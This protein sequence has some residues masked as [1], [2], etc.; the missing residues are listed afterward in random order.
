[1]ELISNDFKHNELMDKKF[2]YRADNKS[3][4][5]KWSDPP[6]S[7]KS[8]AISCN[9]PDAP[10]GDWIHW[11]VINIPRDVIEIPQGGPIPGK[12]LE[13]DYGQ[14]GY[15]GPAPPSGTHRYFFKVYALDIEKLEGVNKRNFKEK[16]KKYTLDSAEIIGLYK[17]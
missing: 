15:G 14:K 1:M 3:P 7:T 4:H 10:V 17:S 9:D 12:E 13:N 6:S 8:F 2:S 16:I 11:Y 5:L